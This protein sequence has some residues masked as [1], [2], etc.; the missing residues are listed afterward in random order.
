MPATNLGTCE[1]L[2]AGAQLGVAT[3]GLCGSKRLHFLETQIS[4]LKKH[5]QE[6]NLLGT[7]R[8]GGR[9]M[10]Q[11]PAG[12]SAAQVALERAQRVPERFLTSA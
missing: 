3:L 1:A 11:A 8:R 10:A 4:I 12:P 9:L 6:R 5:Q 2:H 7:G